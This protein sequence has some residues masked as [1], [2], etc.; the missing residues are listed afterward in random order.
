VPKFIHEEI[1]AV[2][3]SNIK[4]TNETIR[5]KI[6][7]TSFAEQREFGLGILKDLGVLK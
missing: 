7:A 2:N 5:D 6:H 4:G 1:N 3:S